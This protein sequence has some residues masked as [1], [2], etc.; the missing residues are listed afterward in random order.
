MAKVKKEVEVSKEVSELGDAVLALVKA[1]KT[2]LADGWQPGADIPA[3]L[4]ACVGQL[5]AVGAVSQVPAS[6]AEDKAA[7]LKACSLLASDLVKELTA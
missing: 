2:S 4:V 5:G 3:I 1:V 6:W 7:V